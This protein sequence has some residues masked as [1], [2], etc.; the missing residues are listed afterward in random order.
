MR[1]F[2]VRFCGRPDGRLANQVIAGPLDRENLL[3]E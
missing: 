1:S 2:K 3:A